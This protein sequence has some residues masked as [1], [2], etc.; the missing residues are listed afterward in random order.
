MNPN[1]QS[2]LENL[3]ENQQRFFNISLIPENNPRININVTIK[4]P[5]SQFSEAAPACIENRRGLPPIHPL[6]ISNENVE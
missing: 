6:S 1:N 4:S 5:L 2:F 3:H